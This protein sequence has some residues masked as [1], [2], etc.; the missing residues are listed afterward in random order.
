MVS[1]L[2]SVGAMAF[3]PAA[4]ADSS[5]STNW[6]GYAVHGGSFHSVS[7]SWRQPSVSCA[8]GHL[9]YSAFWVGLGGFSAGSGALEQ[10]G[11]EADCGLNGQPQLSAWYE[12]VPAASMP[13]TMSVGAGDLIDADV[14]VTGHRAT[15]QL[16]DRTRHRSFHIT[17][18]SPQIDVSSAEWIVE[19]PSD[20][21]T[22]CVALPLANFGTAL[23]AAVRAQN[24]A[25]HWGGISDPA[26]SPTR[27]RLNPAGARFATGSGRVGGAAMASGLG[28]GGTAFSVAFSP[29]PP[30]GQT[31]TGRRFSLR[32]SPVSARS[33]R[34]VH[35]LRSGRR[36]G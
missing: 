20:C 17:V 27:I 32:A 29:L 26:W 2:A 11:T 14:T 36:G 23:F 1:L 6:A 8:R 28:S 5:D 10:I 18:G 15:L 19:A 7:A 34:L 30:P 13:I 31:F 22:S 35:P 4:L 9:S 33:A 25:G 12:M 3:A 16:R 24:E 21:Y